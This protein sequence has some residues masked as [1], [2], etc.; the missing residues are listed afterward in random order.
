[1]VIEKALIRYLGAVRLI[2]EF[3]EVP[4]ALVYPIYSRTS[5]AQCVWD[6]ENLFETRVVPAIEGLL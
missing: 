1:M 6:Y 3:C 2:Y 5:M 4:F